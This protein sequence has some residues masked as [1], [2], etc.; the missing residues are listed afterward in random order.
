MPRLPLVPA[1]LLEEWIRSSS[2]QMA[3]IW[4]ERVGL[5]LKGPDR[6]A[7]WRPQICVSLCMSVSELAVA[8]GLP[9]CGAAVCV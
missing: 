2:N 6:A 8:L 5:G 9:V 7:P 1:A 3:P 4:G